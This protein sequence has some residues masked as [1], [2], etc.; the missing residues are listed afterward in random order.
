MPENSRKKRPVP[1]KIIQV[2]KQTRDIFHP[3]PKKT[4]QTRLDAYRLNNPSPINKDTYYDVEMAQP[5][6]AQYM[7][8]S[9]SPIE[10]PSKPTSPY[11]DPPSAI[12]SRSQ[13]PIEQYMN[14]LDDSDVKYDD[15][16]W[17][18]HD[19]DFKGGKKT[20]NRVKRRR[21]RSSRRKSRKIKQKGRGIGK[22]KP[23][24][25][26]TLPKKTRKHVQFLP[27]TKSPSSPKQ[28][29]TKRMFISKNK[30]KLKAVVQYENRK[31]QQDAED[32]RLGKIP[33]EGGN[34]RK[35]TAKKSK[36]RK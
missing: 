26:D 14:S 23:E 30:D 4:M 15:N 17:G 33:L 21:V 20:R 19:K 1:G 25:T 5:V 3:T 29:K 11:N 35:K 24:K 32:M 13:S 9:F 8:R 16:E 27:E 31:R 12:S 34:K 36:G 22:S 2:V 28:N 18:F 6:K 10:V 7:D